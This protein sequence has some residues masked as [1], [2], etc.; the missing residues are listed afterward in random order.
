MTTGCVLLASVVSAGLVLAAESSKS[1]GA[2]DVISTLTPLQKQQID[3]QRPT[4]HQPTV[5]EGVAPPTTLPLTLAAGETLVFL[6]NGLAESTLIKL[7]IHRARR[8]ECGADFRVQ[9][10]QGTLELSHRDADG[11]RAY[12]VEPRAEL[13]CGDSAAFG[14]LVDD[15]PDRGHDRVDVNPAAGQRRAQ[16]CRGHG[17]AAQVDTGHRETCHFR[18]CP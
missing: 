16:L 2:I 6:G 10:H 4:Y 13:Q 9:P 12:A 3:Q 11:V 1:D 15:R 18:N 5:V 17:A 14:H 7:F 8:I